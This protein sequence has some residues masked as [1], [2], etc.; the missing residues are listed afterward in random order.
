ML[1]GKYWLTKL[2]PEIICH[3]ALRDWLVWKHCD[4]YT[5]GIL[6]V[7]FSR[8]KITLWFELKILPRLTTSVQAN[9]LKKLDEGAY[10]IEVAKDLKGAAILGVTT[11]DFC[12]HSRHGGVGLTSRWIA[13]EI[14]K[15]CINA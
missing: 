3:S 6:D 5:E 12:R 13:N 15:R 14:A 2:R 9:N 8:G 10:L 7:S 4:R 11:Y 1:E